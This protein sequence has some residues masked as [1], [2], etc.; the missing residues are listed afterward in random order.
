[1]SEWPDPSLDKKVIAPELRCSLWA[2]IENLI[3]ADN[4]AAAIVGI[5]HLTG[6]QGRI[7]IEASAA[8]IR[9]RDLFPAVCALI[10]HDNKHNRACGLVT[11]IGLPMPV[12]LALADSPAVA[13]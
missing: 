1:M 3:A 9:K 7:A 8:A 13:Q 2:E 4:V 10:N 6:L 12:D 5:A 11:V